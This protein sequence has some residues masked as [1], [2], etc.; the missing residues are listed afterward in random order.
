[1]S[2]VIVYT[3]S[4]GSLAVCYPTG[5]LPIEDVLAKDCPAGAVIID[6]SALPQGA[7]LQFPESWE[8]SGMTVTVNFDKAQV[9]KLSQFNSAAVAVAQKRQLNTLA[10]I[11]NFPDDATWMAELTAGR[12]AIAAATTVDQLVAIPNPT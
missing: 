9:E 4:D 6:K 10:G 3:E 11:P 7:D 8:L 1:M 12:D 5:E 2:Q